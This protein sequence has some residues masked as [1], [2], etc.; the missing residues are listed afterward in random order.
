MKKKTPNLFVTKPI[1]PPFEDFICSLE[2]IWES[3]IITNNGPFH[4]EFEL[5]LSKYLGVKNISVFNNGSHDKNPG[6][7]RQIQSLVL[8][9]SV[10][11]EVIEPTGRQLGI[12][13]GVADAGVSEILLYCP[14]VLPL[15][16]QVEAGGMSEHM[17]MDAEW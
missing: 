6:G 9:P 1:L 10:L 3:G 4:Q 15:I 2:R 5:A 14:R 7:L 16:G 17:S 8:P 11:P 13:D 12:P